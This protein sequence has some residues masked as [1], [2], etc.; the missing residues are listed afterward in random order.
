L[1]ALSQ[2]EYRA[3]Y[4][5]VVKNKDQILASVQQFFQANICPKLSVDNSPFKLGCYVIDFGV[6]FHHNIAHEID[7]V[8]TIV[9]E[10]NNFSEGCELCLFD[11]ERDIDVLTWKKEFE[12]RI[13][14]EIMIDQIDYDNLFTSEYNEMKKFI[15]EQITKNSPNKSL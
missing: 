14:D 3:F 8:E 11:W 10:L 9:I 13:V 12:F 5:G 2:Y 1:F 15:K 6:I 4:H 7:Q